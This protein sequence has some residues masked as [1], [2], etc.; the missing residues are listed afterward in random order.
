MYSALKS[1]GDRYKKAAKG[2][3]VTTADFQEHFQQVS[4]DRYER[5]AEEIEEAAGE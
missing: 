2:H 1:S 5:G 4:Q 3:N